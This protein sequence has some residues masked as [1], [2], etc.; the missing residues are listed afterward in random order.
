MRNGPLLTAM[1]ACLG[2]CGPNLVGDGSRAGGDARTTSSVH[3]MPFGKTRTRASAPAGAQLTYYGG[4]VLAS[5]K[6][7]TLFWNG[8]VV[9]QDQINGFYGA[10][11]ASPYFDWLSEYN[12][13]SQSIG[14]GTL[15]ATVVDGQGAGSL[16]DADV[17]G[18][19]GA[20]ID[21]GSLPPVDGN[22]LYMVHF[23]PNTTITQGSGDR[24]CDVF[25]AYHGTFQKGGASV[26]YG[27]VPDMGGACAGGCGDGSQIDN[28][29]AVASHELIEAVTDA[30]VGLATTLGPPLAWYDQTNGEIGDICNGQVS[31]VAGYTVQLEWSNARGGCVAQ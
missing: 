14:R 19:I 13:P 22:T 1:L 11:T 3:A 26:Y 12:T 17:Q 31:T 28:T 2:G 16:A 9:G 21:A 8:D 30:G 23:P 18:E 29:T 6:V 4:P 15:G 27:V 10:V 25:C 20:L 5:V 24:S 7:V